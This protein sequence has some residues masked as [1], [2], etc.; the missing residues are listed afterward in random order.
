MDDRLSFRLHLGWQ[1][2]ELVTAKA[3][4]QQRFEH[5]TKATVKF[6]NVMATASW[7]LQ[8]APATCSLGSRQSSAALRSQKATKVLLVPGEERKGWPRASSVEL[9]DG[10]ALTLAAAVAA[11]SLQT[12]QA[13]RAYI[14]QSCQERKRPLGPMQELEAFAYGPPVELLPTHSRCRLSERA[15]TGV[16]LFRFGA[17]WSPS[18]RLVDRMNIAVRGHGICASPKR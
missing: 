2:S 3:R 10:W 11:G 16:T 14:Q 15:V 12:G 1:P 18:R 17:P 9:V 5:E 8:T 13:G 7:S 6:F 4:R